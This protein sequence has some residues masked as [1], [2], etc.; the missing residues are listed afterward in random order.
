M[1]REDFKPARKA[2]VLRPSALKKIAKFEVKNEKDVKFFMDTV[3]HSVNEYL[4]YIA[5][6]KAYQILK[7]QWYGRMEPVY[8]NRTMD[9]LSALNVRMDSNGY[10]NLGIDARALRRTPRDNEGEMGNVGDLGQHM[11]FNDEPVG[12][13]IWTYINYGNKSSKISYAGIDIIKQVEDFLNR[14]AKRIVKKFLKDN[15][16]EVK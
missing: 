16:I 6:E 4:A 1:P 7:E 13:E 9:L 8:Y 2:K 14:H 3:I 15:N 10:Y 11:G 5:Y 12:A